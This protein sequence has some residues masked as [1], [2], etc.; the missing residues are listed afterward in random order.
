MDN[1][2]LTRKKISTQESHV[3]NICQGRMSKVDDNI[4]IFVVMKT[5]K[6][7]KSMWTFDVI[8]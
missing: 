8:Q 4:T 7:M 1:R 5:T 2:F 3:I 6:L